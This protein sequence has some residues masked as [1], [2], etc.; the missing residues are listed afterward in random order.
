MNNLKLADELRKAGVEVCFGFGKL[1]IHA[2]LALVTKIENNKEF[3]YTHLSTGNYHSGNARAY[4][5]L[6]I[7]TANQDI[8]RDAKYFFDKVSKGELP[9][10]FK[11]LQAA[12]SKLHKTL[13]RLIDIEIMAAKEKKQARIFAKVNALVEEQIIEKLYEASKAG[14]KVDLV[15]RS[16]CSLVPG[17]KG[18]SENIQ[19]MS[20]V[21]RFLEHS[22]IYYFENSKSIYLSSADWMQRNF[23]NRMEIAFPILDQ[24]IF[25]YIKDTVI[26]VTLNDTVKSYELTPQG[27]WKKRVLGSKKIRSQFFFEECAKNGYKNTA[28]EKFNE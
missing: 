2:K 24:R 10:K 7:L 14:V 4:T 9:T 26:T 23:F 18:L 28:L 3:Y 1:K 15:V 27:T 13:L 8:G 12:P 25:N 20:I 21:D 19:V 6:A 11:I 5:D 22:R 16:A 17:V